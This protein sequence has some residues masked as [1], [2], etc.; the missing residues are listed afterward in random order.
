M[1]DTTRRLKVQ[2]YQV[3]QIDS[4]Y[5]SAYRLRIE[6]TEAVGLDRRVFVYRRDQANPYTG[7]A[8]DTFFSVT[9]PVDLEEYPPEEPDPNKSYPFFRKHFVE[10][11]FRTVGLAR[12]TELLIL[13]ELTV[14]VHALN[15]LEALDSEVEYE[16]GPF[17]NDI[18][19]E[20]DSFSDSLSA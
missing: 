1:P 5:Y 17:P 10:L 6:V 8:T 20:G 11:D 16:I 2:R 18:P 3:E 15:K 13:E 14:L 4:L 12:A 7:Q 9:S 19:G